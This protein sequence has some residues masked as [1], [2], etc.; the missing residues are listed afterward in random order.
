[1]SASEGKR[2]AEVA[3][4][5]RAPRLRASVSFAPLALTAAVIAFIGCATFH[6]RAPTAADSVGPVSIP[7]LV[8]LIRSTFKPTS[9]DGTPAP[10]F[11]LPI[12]I[13]DVD[14]AQLRC[15]WKPDGSVNVRDVFRD[16]PDWSESWTA[17]QLRAFPRSPGKANQTLGAGDNRTVRLAW[18]VTSASDVESAEVATA[19]R[20]PCTERRYWVTFICAGPGGA[21]VLD[22]DSVWRD[23]RVLVRPHGDAWEVTD[24]LGGGIADGSCFEDGKE[25][26]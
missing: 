26:W 10:F 22:L 4:D 21:A 18:R 14:E 9:R 16:D 5:E 6:P 1:M 23:E 25:I 8:S 7:G 17:E 3:D 2:R 24:N 13:R 11:I 20:H 15:D 19:K 12:G